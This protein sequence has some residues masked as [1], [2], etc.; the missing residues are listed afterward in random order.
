MQ[1]NCHPS[2]KIS[3]T[4]LQPFLKAKPQRSTNPLD[5]WRGGS[6]LDELHG[7]RASFDVDSGGVSGSLFEQGQQIVRRSTRLEKGPGVPDRQ[8]PSEVACT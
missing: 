7:I 6:A 8:F 1:F 3:S 2:S 4:P 5:A